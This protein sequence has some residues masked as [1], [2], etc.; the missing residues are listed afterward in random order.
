MQFVFRDGCVG[1]IITWW[2]QLLLSRHV[3]SGS[4]Q[5]RLPVIRAVRCFSSSWL[6]MA[7]TVSV[8]WQTQKLRVKYSSLWAL[9]EIS[10]SLF[11]SGSSS[12][13]T[14]KNIYSEM[15]G[16]CCVNILYLR[17]CSCKNKVS[18]CRFSNDSMVA[19]KIIEAN[20]NNDFISFI[21]NTPGAS[22]CY[23]SSSIETIQIRNMKRTCYTLYEH[24]S[25]I[26][27]IDWYSD[28]IE[29]LL[30]KYRVFFSFF[31]I[32]YIASNDC[33]GQLL[34]KILTS[35]LLIFH[36]LFQ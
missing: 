34:L 16:N 31:P 4:E 28:Y 17:Y 30:S 24:T 12:L 25:T 20:I 10:S 35:H 13:K 23:T 21:L 32:Q 15:R 1:S 7:S 29:Y 9:T 27:I 33:W 26:P 11:K 14:E 2:M 5:S 3:E 18:L 22:W 36:W 6:T 19:F 8:V